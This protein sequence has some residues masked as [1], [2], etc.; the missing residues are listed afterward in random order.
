MNWYN[1]IMA[2]TALSRLSELV[3]ST[4]AR[5]VRLV[6]GAILFAY[7]VSH[8]LNHA[9]GNVSVDAMQIGVYYHTLFWQFLPVA[10]VF[11][12]AALTHMG[13]GVYA[14]FQRRQSRCGQIA[15]LQLG[16]GLIIPA[17]GRAR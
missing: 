3:R 5:Q 10:I 9:L 17:L 11:Y 8:F 6:C 2:A 7:V 12:G 15:P 1:P 13:L 4:S 16:L 14:L